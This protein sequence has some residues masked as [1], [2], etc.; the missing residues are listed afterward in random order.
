MAGDS[1]LAVG[2]HGLLGKQN[3]YDEDG[4]HSPLIISGKML[5]EEKQGKTY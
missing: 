3:I 2:N 5:R 4:I 1:G